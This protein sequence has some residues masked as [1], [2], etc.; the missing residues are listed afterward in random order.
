MEACQRP[1]HGV[2]NEIM[3]LHPRQVCVPRFQ[4]HPWMS[5]FAASGPGIL[6]QPHLDPSGSR[7][8]NES[9]EE[10]VVCCLS[11]MNAVALKMKQALVVQSCFCG[12]LSWVLQRRG[13]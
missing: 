11:S 6:G 5:V 9:P 7:E 12:Y 10:P 8:I 4:T 3:C 2:K 1:P 13:S